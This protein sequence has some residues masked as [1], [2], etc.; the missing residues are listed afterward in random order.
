MCQRQQLHAEAVYV[1]GRM[2]SAK[3][4]LQLVLG[5]LRDVP[6][7]VEFCADQGDDDLWDEL[8]DVALEERP[9]VFSQCSAPDQTLTNI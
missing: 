5:E 3:Q 1:L 2:G 6:R 4:A 9:D 7:A 8:L